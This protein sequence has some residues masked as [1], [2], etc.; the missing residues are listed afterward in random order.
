MPDFRI[1]QFAT[2]TGVQTG[3]LLQVLFLGSWRIP[4]TIPTTQTS[5]PGT[6]KQTEV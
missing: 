4:T 3:K 6:L 2:P 5:L 1:P